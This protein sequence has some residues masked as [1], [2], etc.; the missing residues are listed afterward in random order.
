MSKILNQNSNEY[1]YDN[2]LSKDK[3]LAVGLKMLAFTI[4]DRSSASYKNIMKSRS[5]RKS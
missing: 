5:T 2:R 4:H 3:G 1:V